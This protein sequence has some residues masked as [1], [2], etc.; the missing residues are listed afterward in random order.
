VSDGCPY[1]DRAGRRI[2]RDEWATRFEDLAYKRI[3]Y[4]ELDGVVVSTVWIGM[5][6]SYAERPPL[7]FETMVFS[8]RDTLSTLYCQRYATEEGASTGHREV[9][10]L[11]SALGAEAFT[12][13]DTER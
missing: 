11:V 1:F 7:I 5:D 4:D 3:G 9:A 10:A 8:D 2:G 6:M 13:G 12:A